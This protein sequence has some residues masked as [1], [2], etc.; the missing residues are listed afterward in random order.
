M[1]IQEI[2]T[3]NGIRFKII[4]YD[5]YIIDKNGKYKQKRI[6][7]SYNP[8]KDMPIRQARRIAKQMDLDFNEQYSKN[9]VNGINMKLADLW[10]WYVQY[11]APNYIRESTLRITSLIMNKYILPELGHIK[12]GNF[13]TNRITMFLN[14]CCI[15]KDPKT[16]KPVRPIKYHKDS[17]VKQIYAKLRAL[18]QVAI[19]QGWIK[20]NPCDNAIRPK[21]NKSTKKPALETN[22]IKDILNKVEKFNMYNAVIKFQIYTGMRI[23]ETLALTWNDIDFK[24]KTINVNKTVTYINKEYKIGPPKTEN[25]YRQLGMNN[26]IYD[27]LIKIKKFQTLRKEELE[28]VWIDHNLVFTSDTG[29]YIH[30]NSIGK[31][32]AKITKDTDYNYITIHSLRHANATLLLLNGVDLKIVSSHLGHSD[33]Q[34]TADIYVDVLK[35]Q[36]QKVAQL[37]EF[38]LL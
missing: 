24:N 29:T 18:F 6:F 14:E 35:S 31:R 4:A 17:Y 33:I 36:K 21:R 25:S 28:N 3:K 10:H 30:R 16:N 1:A 15:V 11:Y 22:Q 13:T 26:S 20:D 9:Q 12:L 5:G 7:K 27:L 8:P 2:K 23:G 19:Q 38:N 32:L 37:I 34:T